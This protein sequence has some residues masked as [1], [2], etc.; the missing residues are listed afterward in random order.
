MLRS[1][2]LTHWLWPPAYARF[3]GIS[4]SNFI[5]NSWRVSSEANLHDAALRTFAGFLARMGSNAFQ[6][7]WP[8]VKR[9]AFHE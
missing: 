7:F 1:E 3:A 8:D 4:G 5:A 6:E 9:R 2:V